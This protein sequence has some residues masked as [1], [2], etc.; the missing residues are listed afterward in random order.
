MVATNVFVLAQS[1]PDVLFA[2]VTELPLHNIVVPVMLLRGLVL[3][4]TGKVDEQP[5]LV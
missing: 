5:A 4:V 2:S 3:I 1:P